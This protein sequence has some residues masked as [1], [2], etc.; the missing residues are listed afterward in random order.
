MTEQH[1]YR[2]IRY[3]STRGKRVINS[4]LTLEQAQAHCSDP[5][6]SSRTCRKATN[7]Q[8]THRVGAWFDTYAQE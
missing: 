7:R 2:I 8:R 3:Y 6:T 4:G 1:Y 5:E